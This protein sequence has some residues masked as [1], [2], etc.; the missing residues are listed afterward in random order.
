[1]FVKGDSTLR[2]EQ[3]YKWIASLQYS[4]PVLNVRLDAYL[5]WINNYIY[6]QPTRRNII[7]ISGAYPVFQYRQTR[8]YF[9]GQL[10]HHIPHL[11][12]AANWEAVTVFGHTIPMPEV[13]T[14]TKQQTDPLLDLLPDNIPAFI[15][16]LN[17]NGMVN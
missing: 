3:S 15:A 14:H 11:I 16:T 17:N 1:M 13:T 7:V 2:S 4:H 10:I 12:D 8:A 9:R 5:Q 6:D